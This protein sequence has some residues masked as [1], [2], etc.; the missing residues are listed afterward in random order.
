MDFLKKCVEDITKIE[1]STLSHEEFSIYLTISKLIEY[2]IPKREG[3]IQY[4]KEAYGEYCKL[5]KEALKNNTINLE[6]KT[7]EVY[8]KLPYDKLDKWTKISIIKK[9]LGN[10]KAPVVKSAY[11]S[12][13]D[14][15]Y[16]NEIID[17]SQHVM[18]RISKLMPLIQLMDSKGL[19][20]EDVMKM[21]VDNCP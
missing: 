18:L 6:M 7:F 13:I 1:P 14:N 11:I 8:M 5:F 19:T 12:K 15:D 2:T 10:E 9:L 21:I 16:V 4:N 3:K 17:I 20:Q